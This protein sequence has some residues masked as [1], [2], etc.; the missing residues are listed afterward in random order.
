MAAVD[1]GVPD[2]AFDGAGS[3]LAAVLKKAEFWKQHSAANINDGQRDI[4]NRML[5]G[6]E[7][8]STDREMFARYRAR[9]YQRT[10]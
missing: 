4:L 3:I 7:Q 6:F 5:D 10:A 8:V 1:F 9:R 2:R